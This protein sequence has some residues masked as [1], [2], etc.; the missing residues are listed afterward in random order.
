MY[1]HTRTCFDAT[2]LSTP[3][4]NTIELAHMIAWSTRL[5]ASSCGANSKSAFVQYNMDAVSDFVES[6]A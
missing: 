3:R 6:L 1:L 4:S 2:S 5:Q